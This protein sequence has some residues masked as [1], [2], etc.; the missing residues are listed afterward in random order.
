MAFQPRWIGR[1][2]AATYIPNTH[3]R[4]SAAWRC[5]SLFHHR[6][7]S[8]L[9]RVPNH[10]MC[11]ENMDPTQGLLLA[12][13]DDDAQDNNTSSSDQRTT[14]PQKQL[15]RG[16]IPWFAWTALLFTI[17]FMILTL[18]YASNATAASHI[19]FLYNSSSKTIFVLSILSS[20]TGLFLTATI[21][22]T[23][24]RVQWLLISRPNGLRLTRYLTLQPGTGLMGLL[25]LLFGRSRAGTKMWAMVRMMAIVLVPISSIVIMSTLSPFIYY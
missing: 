19:Q 22:A 5:S 23:F 6:T 11:D 8:S 4:I 10:Q 20:I 25:T 2:K 21:A 18:V 9:V 15:K 24:E 7:N 12:R 1:C 14:I 13:K 3:S 16:G 17:G